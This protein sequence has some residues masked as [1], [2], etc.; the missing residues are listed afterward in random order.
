M[1]GFKP[2]G[3]FRTNFMSKQLIEEDFERRFENEKRKIELDMEHENKKAKEFGR[4]PN[5]F[6]LP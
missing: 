4:K 5:Q 6:Y 1:Y 2:F 3:S